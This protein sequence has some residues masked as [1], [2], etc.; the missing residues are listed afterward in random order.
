M[1]AICLNWISCGGIRLP[2]GWVWTHRLNVEYL[3]KHIDIIHS[4]HC[5]QCRPP[6]K[7]DPPIAGKKAA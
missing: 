5:T 4:T 1:T 2:Y 3:K 6:A 7:P